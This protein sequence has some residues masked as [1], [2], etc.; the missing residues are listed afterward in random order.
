ME[1]KQFL[2]LGIEEITMKKL[3]I[4]LKLFE[5]QDLS[6]L[7][8]WLGIVAASGQNNQVEQKINNLKD[9]EEMKL[10]QLESYL[11]A[12]DNQGIVDLTLY[13]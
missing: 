6:I 4:W 9:R 11:M 1:V 2:P 5:H 7:L 8:I 3:I 13:L 12:D 10:A